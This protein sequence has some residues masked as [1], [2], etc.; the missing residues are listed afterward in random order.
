[1]ANRVLVEESL[2]VPEDLLHEVQ[3]ACLLPWKIDLLWIG[4][5]LTIEE[6]CTYNC[7]IEVLVQVVL[8]AEAAKELL[9]LSIV[10]LVANW[11]L[12]TIHIAVVPVTRSGL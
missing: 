12:I 2:L 11:L 1:M 3:R 10:G 9:H 6:Q 4:G 8:G 7:L 5:K